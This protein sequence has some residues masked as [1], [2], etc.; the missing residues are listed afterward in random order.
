M[1]DRNDAQNQCQT[2]LMSQTRKA[3]KREGGIRYKTQLSLALRLVMVASLALPLSLGGHGL[4]RGLLVCWI[5]GRTA[6]APT[7]TNTA[8]FLGMNDAGRPR[9]PQQFPP[10]RWARS[11]HH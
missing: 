2:S 6:T 11:S 7:P 8:G 3:A 10:G 9:R 5:R 4:P 1:A